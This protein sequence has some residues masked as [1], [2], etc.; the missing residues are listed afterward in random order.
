MLLT[1]PKY[2]RQ[3]GRMIL[4]VAEPGS[5]VG[6]SGELGTGK[7]ELVRALIREACGDVQVQSPSY[8]LEYEYPVPTGSLYWESGFKRIVHFDFY[9]LSGALE[10]SGLD[11]LSPSSEDLYLVEWPE[12]LDGVIDLLSHH[13]E[14]KFAA[15]NRGGVKKPLVV[16]D[17]D[18]GAGIA[19]SE[20]L[21]RKISFLKGFMPEDFPIS[22][23]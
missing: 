21:A 4:R 10:E 7:T 12:K 17:S 14:L 8:I 6:I 2:T 23:A 5:L 9:R 18:E 13:I 11:G 15:L 16:E 20:S 3:I 19:S 1:S 22:E